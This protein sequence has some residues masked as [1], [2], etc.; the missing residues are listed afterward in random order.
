MHACIRKEMGIVLSV[1][2][3]RKQSASLCIRSLAFCGNLRR[4]LLR[5]ALLLG[6]LV[7]VSG[8]VLFENL[9]VLG[10]EVLAAEGADG[11]GFRG[12]DGSAVLVNLDTSAGGVG[13]L[14][15]A[16]DAVLLGDRHSESG[17]V[18]FWL[19]GW[20]LLWLLFLWEKC[21][22]QKVGD[23]PKR[24]KERRPFFHK[25]KIPAVAAVTARCSRHRANISKL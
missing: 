21:E 6:P 24:W 17:F 12:L 9:G 13:F 16:L 10:D 20:L 8:S 19:L 23:D 2:V 25:E 14:V 18:V 5:E 4:E 22:I 7:V 1:I 11:H 15:L 3:R